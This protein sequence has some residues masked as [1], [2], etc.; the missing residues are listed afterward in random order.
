MAHKIEAESLLHARMAE[1]RQRPFDELLKLL[2]EAD[3]VELSG[4]NGQR[5]Q[6]EINAMWDDRAKTRLRVC[7]SIDDGGLRAWINW[8]PLLQDVIAFSDG[9]K[10]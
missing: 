10:E 3:V 4:Q 5:Y 7:G 2:D 6:V 8:R 1:V 9:R